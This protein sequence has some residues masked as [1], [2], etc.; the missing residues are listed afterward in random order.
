[1]QVEHARPARAAVAEAVPRAGRRGQ[2]RAG[3]YARG[4]RADG[5]LHLTLEHEERVSLLVVVVRVDAEALVEAD[6]EGGELR[7]VTENR[8]RPVRALVAL[9]VAG[10]HDHG[11]VGAAAA[12]LRRR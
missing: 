3:P 1:M 7:L 2:P 12:V 11:V 8:D 6:V 5:E 9:A 10:A 4:F